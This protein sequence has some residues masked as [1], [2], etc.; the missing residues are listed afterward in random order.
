MRSLKFLKYLN[1]AQDLKGKLKE[2]VLELKEK[3]NQIMNIKPGEVENQFFDYLIKKPVN[4]MPKKPLELISLKNSI[5]SS[6]NPTYNTVSKDND[7]V[8]ECE[9]IARPE[10]AGGTI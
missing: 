7:T 9:N 6:S 2:L 3:I 8:P 5:G 10:E 4:V 1:N